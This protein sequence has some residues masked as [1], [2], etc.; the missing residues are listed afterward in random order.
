M[1]CRLWLQKNEENIFLLHKTAVVCSFVSDLHGAVNIFK[2][3]FSLIKGQHVYVI[4]FP[5]IPLQQWDEVYCLIK[6]GGKY[7]IK[8][9]KSF[10]WYCRTDKNMKI[11][12]LI[13][14]VYYEGLCSFSSYSVKKSILLM[15]FLRIF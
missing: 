2:E 13:G 10:S 6:K 11:Y 1:V 14:K 9:E 5:N 12:A 7:F 8:T 3:M 15:H 4:I